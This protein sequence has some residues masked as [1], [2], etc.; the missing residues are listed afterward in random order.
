MKNLALH[1]SII[2]LL[3]SALAAQGILQISIGV[4]E[5]GFGGSTVG[6]IGADGGTGG[7]IEWVAQDVQ[8]LPVDG[9]WH[10]FTFDFAND[11][12]T[13]FAG[14]SANG[15]LEGMYGT[16]EHIRVLNTS[17]IGDPIVLLVDDVV[18][19]TGPAGSTVATTVE[20]FEGYGAGT[21]VMFRQAGFS[22]STGTNLM[23]GSTATVDDMFVGSD[24][25]L[26]HDFQ[27]V[28][29]MTNRWARITTFN[30]ANRPN[31]VVRFD[32]NSVVTFRLL[33][34]TSE[35]T[36]L[37]L[38]GPGTVNATFVGDGLNAG[39][40]STIHIGGAP[41]NT[42]GVIG[43]SLFGFPNLPVLGGTVASGSAFF[44]PVTAIADGGGFASVTFAGSS[45]VA[46]FAMQGIYLDNSLPQGIAFSNAFQASFGQ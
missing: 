31:P 11:P 34:Y 27:F 22:G 41:A 42:F 40:A 45:I 35:Q 39:Q 5:T 30:T 21:S 7:G 9:A 36:D 15:T 38:Q 4:R 37:G 24:D 32:N 10:T 25:V 12:I 3:S 2:S 29:T 20:D 6:T 33:A 28:D 1:V 17:G 46:D 44:F 16:I 19:T 13:A 23:T 43:V 14:S 18:N 26:R 8:A